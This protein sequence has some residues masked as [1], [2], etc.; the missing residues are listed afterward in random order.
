MK[1]AIWEKDE[2]VPKLRMEKLKLSGGNETD[3]KRKRLSSPQYIT[4]SQ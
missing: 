2:P 3:L 1:G 4:L